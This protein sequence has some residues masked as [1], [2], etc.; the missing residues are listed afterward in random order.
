[1]TTKTYTIEL[2]VDVTNA[3]MDKTIL[4]MAKQGAATLITR[5]ALVSNG[6]KPQVALMVSDFFG[7][8][9]DLK[10]TDDASAELEEA[11]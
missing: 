1:M 7:T 4:E 6:K 10:I 11:L 5:A 3:D 8:N 9:E 2:R